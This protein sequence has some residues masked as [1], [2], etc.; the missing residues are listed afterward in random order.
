[1]S[2]NIQDT[3][4]RAPDRERVPEAGWRK[5]KHGRGML[6]PFAPGNPGR[7]IAAAT[8]FIETQQFAR[9]HSL[10]AMRTLVD[11]LRDPDGRIAVV[12]A[13]SLLERAWGKVKE[14]KPEDAQQASIDLSS[15]SAEELA[16]M[17][18]LVQ[19]GRLKAAPEDTVAGE[20]IEGKAE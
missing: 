10:E 12:A 6:K 9:S 1:M 19:S 20:T 17:V 11:R 8:R 15:L 16:I 2:A 14:A 13:N 3:G 4:E 5:P 7:P 18:R